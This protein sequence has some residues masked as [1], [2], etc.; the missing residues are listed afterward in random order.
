M[1][2]NENQAFDLGS[3]LARIGNIPTLKRQDGGQ[4]EPLYDPNPIPS[5]YSIPE[6]R[7]KPD[8]PQQGHLKTIG[9]AFKYNVPPNAREST[10][11][12]DRRYTHPSLPTSD[13]G[14]PQR[15]GG[16]A[17]PRELLPFSAAGE[18][19]MAGA[20][21]GPSVTRGPWMTNTEGRLGSRTEVSP[22]AYTLEALMQPSLAH[23][24][25]TAK[26]GGDKNPP[27][28][29]VVQPSMLPFRNGGSITDRTRQLLAKLKNRA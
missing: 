7:L 27:F 29:T 17:V 19:G 12:E 28:E 1:S 6:E 21:S 11:I 23:D 24:F 8:D 5:H 4:V 26:W 14:Y 2:D 22:S 3:A 9:D 18:Q 20:Q 25:N 16:F 10:N 15:L 13:R